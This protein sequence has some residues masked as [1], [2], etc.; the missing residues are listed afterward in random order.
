[1]AN[2]DRISES[3]NTFLYYEGDYVQDKKTVKE[4]FIGHRAMFIKVNTRD[5]ERDG[6]GEMK[7]TD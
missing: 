2:K 4:C 7:W 5:D 3:K 6:H 1:L